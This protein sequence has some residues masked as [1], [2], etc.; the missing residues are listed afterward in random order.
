[1]NTGMLWVL[2][3]FFLFTSCTSIPYIS[4]NYKIPAGEAPSKG[5]T[6][7]LVTLDE[8]KTKEVIGP[9]A[10]NDYKNYGGDISYSLTKGSGSSFKIHSSYSPA[11]KE[12]VLPAII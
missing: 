10:K 7:A 12:R 6:L 4:V 11:P 5:Q 2:M 8:R 3:L 1:M 9:G